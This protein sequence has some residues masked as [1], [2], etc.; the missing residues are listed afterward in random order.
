MPSTAK[1]A[2]ASRSTEERTSEHDEGEK[3]DQEWKLC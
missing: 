2:A 1:A 3:P